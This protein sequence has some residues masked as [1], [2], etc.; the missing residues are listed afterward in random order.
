MVALVVCHAHPGQL[1][2]GEV[3]LSADCPTP[4]GRQVDVRRAL[5]AGICRDLPIPRYSDRLRCHRM[6]VV[7]SAMS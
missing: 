1:G 3:H 2:C 5:G 6:D 4:E 7:V